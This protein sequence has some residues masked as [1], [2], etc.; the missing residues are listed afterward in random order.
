MGLHL[1]STC[2]VISLITN[3]VA[4]YHSEKVY[5]HASIYRLRLSVISGPGGWKKTH[6]ELKNLSGIGL[7]WH[8]VYY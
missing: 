3:T 5:Y 2:D 6:K 8:H 7:H 4:A 1:R